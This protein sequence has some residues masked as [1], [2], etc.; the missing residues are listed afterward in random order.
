MEALQCSPAYPRI[1]RYDLKSERER[2][3]ERFHFAITSCNRNK[4]GSLI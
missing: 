4:K 1:Q 2:E 3:R